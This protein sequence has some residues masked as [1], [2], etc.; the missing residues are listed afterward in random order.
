MS[1]LSLKYK[2]GL[3]WFFVINGILFLVDWRERGDWNWFVTAS[4]LVASLFEV[5]K[6]ASSLP[7]DCL[8][9]ELCEFLFSENVLWK[10]IGRKT[11]LQM[12]EFSQQFFLLKAS[13]D[14]VNSYIINLTR[15]SVIQF[16]KPTKCLVNLM[17]LT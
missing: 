17:F 7:F 6:L 8:L 14:N 9:H 13:L 5:E 11:L 2:D 4:A 15:R 10:Q 16:R 3:D 12:K 1:R